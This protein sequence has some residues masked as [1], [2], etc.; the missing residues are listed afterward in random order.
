MRSGCVALSIHCSQLTSS[1]D[2]PIP[3]HTISFHII[4]AVWIQRK[5]R[6]TSV[7]TQYPLSARMLRPASNPDYYDGLLKE[8]K[9][10]PGRSWF[11]SVVKRWKGALRFT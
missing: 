7:P 11:G 9:E 5:D 10:A 2:D 6:L 1:L 4:A 8:L 3:Y